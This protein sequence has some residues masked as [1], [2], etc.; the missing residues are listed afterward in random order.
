MW[1]FFTGLK[2]V[3]LNTVPIDI[4]ILNDASNELKKLTKLDDKEQNKID[5]QIF[6]SQDSLDRQIW[7]TN[8]CKSLASYFNE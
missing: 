5:T 3:N 2:A 7:M 4:S 1:N 8:L 6:C